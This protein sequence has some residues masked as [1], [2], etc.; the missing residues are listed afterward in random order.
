ML[1]KLMRN[2][3]FLF[4]FIGLTVLITLSFGYEAWLKHDEE[5]VTILYD[6]DGVP[7]DSAPFEPS[8]QYPLGSDNLGENYLYRVIDGAKYTVALAAIISFAQM[9]LSFF[10]GFLLYLSPRKARLTA[11]GL[12]D[13]LHYAP[14]AIFIYLLAGP[15]LDIFVWS[16][17]V[18]TR[19]I[20][21]AIVIVLLSVPVL[22]N[23]IAKELEQIYK[24][25]FIQ[26]APTLGG[27]VFHVF[28]KHVS[29]FLLPKMVVLFLQQISTVLIIFVHLGILEVFIGGSE[30]YKMDERLEN[31]VTVIITEAY[32]LSNEWGGLIGKY[33]SL[34]MAYPWLVFGPILGFSF[35]ILMMNLLVHGLTQSLEIDPF[36]QKKQKR[37]N[38]L[39]KKTARQFDFTKI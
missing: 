32:T 1:L 29:R 11:D 33:W 9:V 38:R 36:V 12:F 26:N 35:V 23:L 14:F 25:E 30:T 17:S 27:G 24:I 31:G 34:Y 20:F 22:S 37:K 8:L 13:T 15:V 39:H 4:S 7:Y 21:P 18:E 6:E 28:R 3:W 16:Y 10:G 5:L 2:P 19:I